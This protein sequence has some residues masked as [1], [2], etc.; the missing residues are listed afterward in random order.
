MTPETTNLVPMTYAEA[1]DLYVSCGR[2]SFSFVTAPYGVLKTVV[3]VLQHG[4]SGE[5]L[6][7][8]PGGV[9]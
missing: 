1:F 6:A 2:R 9:Q 7:V 8:N 4:R 5:V 3:S